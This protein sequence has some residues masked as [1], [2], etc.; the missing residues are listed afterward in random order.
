MQHALETRQL[1][2]H[3]RLF[4]ILLLAAALSAC[5]GGGGT[6]SFTLSATATGG[7]SISPPTA[8]IKRGATASFSLSPA[9]G[10]RIG[11]VSGCGGALSGSSYVTGPISGACTVSATFVLQVYTV[12]ASAGAGGSI[13]PAS[14]QVEHGSATTFTLSPLE[15]YSI[16]GATGCGGALSGNVYSTGPI[17]A[18]CTVSAS[19]TINRYDVSASAGPGGSI[20]PAGAEVEHGST[21]AF[22]LSALENYEVAGVT[23]C[24]GALNGSVYTTGAITGACSVSAS[25]AL[26]RYE[27]TTSAGPGG[28][29]DPAS[30][31]VEH[32]S[33][34][35]FTLVPEEGYSIV[36]AA[37][38]GGALV[39][40]VFTTGPITAA[41]TVSGSFLINRYE[42]TAIAGPGGS[43]R[44]ES[45]EV[46]HGSTA[47]FEVEVEPGYSIDSVSGCGGTLEDAQFLTGPIIGACTVEALFRLPSVSGTVWP[48][49]G[50]GADSDVNDPR[51]AFVSNSS[52]PQAQFIGTPV[53][54]GGYVNR[55]FQ[56]AEGR[57]FSAGDEFDVFQVNL[58]AG[59]E[60]QLLIA[61]EDVADD[62]DLWLVDLEGFLVDASL[63][64]WA[65][66]ESVTVPP[67]A[68]GEYYLVVRAWTGA[69]NYLLVIDATAPATPATMRLSDH[70]VPGELVIRLADDAPAADG[71]GLAQAGPLGSGRGRDPGE[72]QRSQLVSIAELHALGPRVATVAGAPD[73]ER[74]LAEAGG[75]L[76]VREPSMLAKLET[77]AMAKALS[78]DPTV[79]AVT[80]NYLHALH[81][82]FIPD[83][84]EFAKQWH[85]AQISAPEAWTLATGTGVIVAVIDSGVLL[86]HP[87]MAGRL[88]EGHDFLLGTPG[89]DDPGYD[90]VPPGGSTFHGTHVAGTVA[91]ATDNGI[92]VAGVAFDARIMSL[93]VCNV[94]GCPGYA[95]EQAL[96]YA[97][98]LSNDSGVIPPQP[99]Q[100]VNL[101]LG[102]QGGPALTQEQLLYDQLRAL[103]IFVVASAGNSSTSAV[104]YPAAYG[105]VTAVSALDFA[106]QRA[107][108]SN[109]GA[110]IDVAAPG[111][112]LGRDLN[113]DGFP[114]GVL[115][116]SADDRDGPPQP[117]YRFLQG[118]S[119][120]AP[121]VAGVAALM[122][123]AVPELRAQDI[124][125]L[126]RNQ[127]ITDDLGS[128]GKDDIYGWGLINAF[129]AV[130]ETLN[131]GGEPVPLAPFM[132][133]SA[134]TVS[135]GLTL[136]DGAVVFSNIGEGEL[137][138]GV[139]TED[140]GGWLSL[141]ADEV[142][143]ELYL[144]LRAD[145]AGLPEG[146][147]LATVTMPSSANTLE[148]AVVMQVA[149]L[150]GANVGLQYVLL[151]DPD[152][153][154]AL[155]YATAQPAGDGR[156]SFRIENVAPGSYLLVGGS[157]ADNDGAVCDAGESCGSYREGADIA[158]VE[159]A[160]EDLDGLQFE[161]GYTLPAT[162]PES[163]PA[164]G[165]GIFIGRD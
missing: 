20:S 18:A 4:A 81:A 105:N 37:G 66:V 65:R 91:A 88:V 151:L 39:G 16:T 104:A 116:T 6:P 156:Q 158:P 52:Y 98:G 164:P 90:P 27:V 71:T 58:P 64:P 86:A 115:S 112:D 51:A 134:E 154:Q 162:G 142:E 155:Y 32:G 133:A 77:L 120:A 45:V 41:C 157:D 25:F 74:L 84:P 126:L 150:P 82:E 108:Y 147:Y 10:Y 50:T 138:F 36:D 22:T 63:D 7:G 127:V 69:S 80:P 12:S 38:C 2:R 107:F 21:T 43:I 67:G 53:T 8:T 62:L 144:S 46:E 73:A 145:R 135:F 70:F 111:G 117:S 106:G 163:S 40:N 95:I 149:N 24:G 94:D 56:G 72:P 61:S 14:A 102:R 160:D 92:G 124:E 129:K 13:G 17:T 139:P 146:R 125:N 101:S 97:A 30:A 28:R 141:V 75:W 42:V 110:W 83:D 118:T 165:G 31:Q 148:V 114:D 85:Y 55:R 57:S 96:R 136:Q 15:G 121:H 103:D 54:L 119:M 132:A 9:T 59:Q 109:F 1:H 48:A 44:P 137:V 60:V 23:G 68:D 140:S 131:A 122:R 11:S 130:T 128:P 29:I 76:R 99:A 153:M 113:G 26:R 87:D 152:S 123:A 79:A 19:F 35:T 3:S 47:S 143:G 78:R 49:A 89:G 159:V 34:A 100:V 161:S 33:S 5:G 93:R